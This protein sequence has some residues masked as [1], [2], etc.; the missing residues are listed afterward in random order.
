M[1]TK[2]KELS[3]DFKNAGTEWQPKGEP[4][5]LRVHDFLD[6]ELGI[7]RDEGGSG[8]GQTNGPWRLTPRS[9]RFSARPTERRSR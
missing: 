9:L 7:Q 4:E 3:G 1:D 5:P 2:K 6:K 8:N